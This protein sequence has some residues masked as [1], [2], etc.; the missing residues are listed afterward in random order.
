VS[1]AGS[2][3]PM[4]TF[5]M[6]KAETIPAGRYSTLRWLDKPLVGGT[7]DRTPPQRY[8]PDPGCLPMNTRLQSVLDGMS[9]HTTLTGSDPQA[10]GRAA[11]VLRGKGQD[12]TRGGHQT[13]GALGRSTLDR[14]VSDRATV[15]HQAPATRPDTS[16]EPLVISQTIPGPAQGRSARRAGTIRYASVAARSRVEPALRAV[17]A[18]IMARA[19]CLAT[20]RQPANRRNAYT[21]SRMAPFN[22]RSV[23][24]RPQC[25]VTT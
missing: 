13:P 9:V 3:C 24:A 16:R 19:S 11:R 10:F 18:D 12:S 25:V 2:A 1:A 8:V 20:R 4:H 14:D 17:C 5:S 6:R 15:T 7:S 23:T 22:H 21:A